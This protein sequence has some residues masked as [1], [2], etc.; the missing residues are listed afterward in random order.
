MDLIPKIIDP[1]FRWD[2]VWWE[3]HD[4]LAFDHLLTRPWFRRRWV[5]QEAAFSA[6]SMIFCGG[7]KVPMEHFTRPVGLVRSKLS[8]ISESF[9][10]TGKI[11]SHKGCLANFSD[12]PQPGFSI[13]S[14]VFLIGPMEQFEPEDYL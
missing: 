12:S 4:F 6:N 5:I 2:G 7:H 13:S 14:K 3:T 8:S 10:T 9:T 1:D 11:M